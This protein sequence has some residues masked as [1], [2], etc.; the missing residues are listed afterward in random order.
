MTAM[1]Q[2]PKFWSQNYMAS[3]SYTAKCCSTTL[4]MGPWFY[5]P[6]G[7]LH[8]CIEPSPLLRSAPQVTWPSPTC[9]ALHAPAL[10]A[11]CYPPDECNELYSFKTLPCHET[12]YNRIA[13]ELTRAPIKSDVGEILEPHKDKNPKPREQ[14]FSCDGNPIRLAICASWL[15]HRSLQCVPANTRNF[16]LVPTAWKTTPESKEEIMKIEWAF[17]EMKAKL[18]CNAN[19]PQP[20]AS[21]K[22]RLW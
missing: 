17:T 9:R 22:D 2:E 18:C 21:F 14:L 16:W 1:R 8:N 19:C 12:F 15:A 4:C 3:P 7:S 6:S 5:R 20:C 10:K 13:V 11:S